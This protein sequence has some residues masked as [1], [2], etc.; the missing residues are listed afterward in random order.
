MQRAPMC[1]LLS[2]PQ[3]YYL[4]KLK[5]N[6][7]TKILAMIQ[8]I[9][10]TH[11]SPVTCTHLCV[12]MCVYLYTILCPVCVCVYTTTNKTHF[13]HHKNPSCGLLQPCSPPSCSLFNPWQP[14]MQFPFLFPPLSAG[15]SCITLHGCILIGNFSLVSTLPARP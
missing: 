1:P 7:T 9:S 6:I 5:Y 13:L 3:W 14:L 4:A 2:F 8:S 15:T 10:P 12:H 11:V